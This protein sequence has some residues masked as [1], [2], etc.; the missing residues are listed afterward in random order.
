MTMESDFRAFVIAGSDVSALIGTR[1]RHQ[2]IPESDAMPASRM[3]V[4]SVVSDIH[5]NG[6]VGAARAIIQVDN[7][8]DTSEVAMDLAEK[9][10][11]RLV[12]NNN[13]R[14]T[15]GSTVV[16][17]TRLVGKQD[18]PP[19]Q[20]P[21]GGDKWRYNRSLDFELDYTEAAPA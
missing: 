20:E 6:V 8:A 10:R 2:Q 17:Q 18:E 7:Y 21:D 19:L 4:I 1:M 12:A 5:L 14:R 15:M 9:V 11:V 13:G 16:T 3:T